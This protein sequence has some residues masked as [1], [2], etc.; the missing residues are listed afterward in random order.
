MTFLQSLILGIVQGLTEYLPVSSSAH[1][2]IVPYLLDWN[3]PASQIFPFDVLVQWGTLVA[4]I[5][6]FWQDLISIIKSFFVALINKKPF[7]DP[8]ARLGWYL[9][10][11]SIPAALSGLLFKSKVEAA[12]SDPKMTA[13]FL[14]GTA[15][16]LLI[17][18]FLGKR[19]RQLEEMTWWDALWIGLFQ[20][21]SIFPGIS[22][23]GSTIA[24]GMT[25]NFDRSSSTRFSFLMAIPVM[26]GAGLVSLKDLFT[27]PDLGSFLPILAVGFLAAAM[28]GYLSIH[29]LLSYVKRQ[30][31]WV[32]SVYCIAIAL[33][34]LIVSAVRPASVQ[35]SSLVTTS[36]QASSPASQPTLAQ[37]VQIIKLEYSDSF[38]WMTPAMTSCA[39]L[40]ID[41]GL[42]IHALPADELNLQTSDLVLRWGAPANLPASVSQIGTETLAIAVNGKN[43]LQTL[44][45]TQAQDVFSGTYSTWGDLHKACPDCFANYDSSFDGQNIGL[46]F[47]APEEDIQ[48]LFLKRVMADKPVA[49]AAALLIPDPAAMRATLA[50]SSSAIGFLPAHSLGS[51]LKQV[52]LTGIEDSLLQAPILALSTNTPQGKDLQWLLCLQKVVN[53]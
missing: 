5:I 8:Q 19:T 27:V 45:I 23:S 48:Q 24:G 50:D 26:I 29:W 12:F 4:V 34:V 13:W 38:E 47:Y 44:S 31:F 28:V 1:L 6:Y 11:A 46:A 30:K 2:V 18:D 43:S 37:G 17:A 15:A 3:F 52:K 21:I 41:T 25:H 16:L 51:D 49:S 20:A 32:F 42:V 7:E 9:L 33:I 40:L 35:A 22:R 36:A 10:L 14:L 39:N 53:P